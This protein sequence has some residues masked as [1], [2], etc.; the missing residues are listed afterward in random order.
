MA[1]ILDALLGFDKWPA[2]ADPWDK[3]EEPC[4]WLAEET[5]MDC[6]LCIEVDGDDAGYA[7]KPGR[8]IG[9]CRREECF[10]TDEST[11]EEKQLECFE[12]W[13]D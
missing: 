9:W 11:V 4:D 1:R 2:F 12:R 13:W 8:R 5:C 6:Q 3:A 7:L 10:V